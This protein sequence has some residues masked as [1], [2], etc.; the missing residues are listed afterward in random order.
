MLQT[1]AL[2]DFFECFQVQIC[3][4]CCEETNGSVL[5]HETGKLG[6]KVNCQNFSLLV[7]ILKILLSISEVKR[8]SLR[9]ARGARIYYETVGYLLIV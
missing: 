4:L 7:N 3:S 5:T 6:H 1:Q 8:K 2:N 9:V